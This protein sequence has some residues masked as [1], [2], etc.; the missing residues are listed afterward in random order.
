[1]NA[2]VA[3]VDRDMVTEHEGELPMHRPVHVVNFPLGEATKDTT[4]P[5]GNGNTQTPEQGVPLTRTVPG[6]VPP[7]AETVRFTMGANLTVTVLLAETGTSQTVSDPQDGSDQFSSAFP[8]AGIA[9]RVTVVASANVAKHCEPQLI[10]PELQT[11]PD[12]DLRTDK[13]IGTSNRASTDIASSRVT[14]HGPR[15]SQPSTPDQPRKMLPDWAVAVSV[16]SVPERNPRVHG[17]S[18]SSP[19]VLHTTAPVPGPDFVTVR[20]TLDSKLA[21]TDLFS[22]INR[23]QT[24][25][26]PEQSPL[27][28]LKI[29]PGFALA[30][31]LTRVPG[32]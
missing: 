14:T 28:L 5:L 10:K 9:V 20:S 16:T 17:E 19:S 7:V 24:T 4:D 8:A 30:T 13:V 23:L 31:S 11:V 21:I 3:K 29:F 6:P 12:P 2:A 26:V 22:L 15:P 32:L 18:Q 1:M 27:Q 25:V